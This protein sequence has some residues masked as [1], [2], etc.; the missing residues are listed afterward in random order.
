MARTCS[1][2]LALFYDG[3]LIFKC[4]FALRLVSLEAQSGIVL[5]WYLCAFCASVGG[6]QVEA[7]DFISRIN[8]MY[9]KGRV[10]ARTERRGEHVLAIKSHEIFKQ[11]N[12]A[13][14]MDGVVMGG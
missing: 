1:A 10:R 12:C 2:L 14:S 7:V 11:S 6:T 9:M 8:I 5:V 4:I 3:L 13:W